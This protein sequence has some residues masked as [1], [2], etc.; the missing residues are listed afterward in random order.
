MKLQKLFSRRSD[1]GLQQWVM[2]VEGSQYRVTS[3]AVGAKLHTNE[4]TVAVPKNVGRANETTP[5]QQAKLEAQAT[6]DKKYSE[7]YRPTEAEL[8]TVTLFEPMLAKK[9][10]DYP[11]VSYPVYCQ[12]KLDGIRCIAKPDGLYTRK[13]KPHLN[14]EHVAS[15][16]AKVF[17]ANPTLVLDGEGYA[18]KLSNDFNQIVHLIKQQKPTTHDRAD[19]AAMIRYHVYDCYFTDH[20]EYTFA[21]RSQMLQ[22]LLAN[23]KTVQLVDTRLCSDAEVLDAMYAEFLANGYEGQMIRTDTP[24]E[25]K[26]TKA[27]LK[28]KEFVDAE[29]TIAA[30]E[31]GIGNRSGTAG[32]IVLEKVGKSGIRGNLAYFTKLWQERKDIIGKQ[33]TIRYQGVT[34]DGKLRFPVCVAV[35]NYE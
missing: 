18:D 9:L 5:E 15:D 29:Y 11:E 33:A 31:E 7:G 3:G 2:E 6:W 22:D 21:A 27:L 13:G 16:L 8:A 17:K 23:C 35:R 12:P 20:P 30:V 10:A 1:G 25:C 34:P 14:M 28:R 24:Y 26:R 32:A 4:W 19:S